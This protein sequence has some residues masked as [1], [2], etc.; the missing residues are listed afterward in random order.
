MLCPS[1]LSSVEAAK[2]GG[3]VWGQG[4]PSPYETGL[5]AAPPL[6]QDYPRWG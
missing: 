5:A 2:V 4:K 6:R 1:I 3:K